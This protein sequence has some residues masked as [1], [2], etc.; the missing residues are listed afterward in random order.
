MPEGYMEELQQKLSQIPVRKAR[1]SLAPY[2][3]LAASFLVL[4]VAGNFVLRSTQ[5]A[6]PISDEAIIE[7]LIESGATLAQVEN[8][9]QVSY[10]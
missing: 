3:A 4:L 9:Y 2:L 5:S 7:Y 10:K 6:A 1:V 8:A